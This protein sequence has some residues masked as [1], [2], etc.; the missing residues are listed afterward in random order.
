MGLPPR[1]FPRFPCAFLFFELLCVLLFAG[2]VGLVGTVGL[3][4]G[5]DLFAELP[6]FFV[7]LFVGFVVDLGCF[8]AL[9]GVFFVGLF[10]L[11]ALTFCLTLFL[12]HVG[13]DAPFL[14]LLLRFAFF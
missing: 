2:F 5:F 6:R 12:E 10:F 13:H 1:P 4:A 9:L 3:V 7:G 11:F 8:F 14:F